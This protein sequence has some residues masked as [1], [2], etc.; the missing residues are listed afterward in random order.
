MLKKYDSG[1]Y[2]GAPVLGLKRLVVKMHGS[3]KAHDVR[4]AVEQCV[5]FYR[6]DIA[7]KITSYIESNS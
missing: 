5:Q 1:Q 4:R 7:S 6:E 2:G 3:A